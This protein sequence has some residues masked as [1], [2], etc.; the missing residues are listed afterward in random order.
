MAGLDLKGG[1]GSAV[2]LPLPAPKGKLVEWWG[3]RVVVLS[4]VER[5]EGAVVEGREVVL[6]GPPRRGV[7]R[8]MVAE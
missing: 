8:I 5:V 4:Q 1:E 7:L 6:R 2:G 3:T